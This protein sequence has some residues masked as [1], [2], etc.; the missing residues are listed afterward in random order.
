MKQQQNSNEKKYSAVVEKNTR[1]GEG[2]R[3]FVEEEEKMRSDKKNR[4]FIEF[5]FLSEVYYRRYAMLMVVA[6]F[7]NGG[8][9]RWHI[10]EFNCH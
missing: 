10:T 1:M 8:M 5:L 6:M 9:R 7:D 2:G 4:S 3:G